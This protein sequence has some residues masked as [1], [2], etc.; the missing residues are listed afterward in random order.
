MNLTLESRD[1]PHN[2]RM[3][4]GK[5]TNVFVTA[6]LLRRIF[7]SKLLHCPVRFFRQWLD[8][9]NPVHD[10]AQLN[11]ACWANIQ[12][13]ELVQDAIARRNQLAQIVSLGS[14]S[15]G[16]SGITQHS[17]RVPNTHRVGPEAV[18][19]RVG[20]R[21]EVQAFCDIQF[22][23]DLRR[24]PWTC[25]ATSL[26]QPTGKPGLIETRSSKP[27]VKAAYVLWLGETV[28]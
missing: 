25:N 9:S 23:V 7:L 6:V 28:Q 16:R 18:D 15:V 10:S 1:I 21:E 8:F 26:L 24:V 5:L 27:I 14:T 12:G 2:L 20:A 11:V 13:R 17:Q 22:D 3:G 4:I 19:G